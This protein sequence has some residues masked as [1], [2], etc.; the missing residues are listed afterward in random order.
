MKKHG[1]SDS[2]FEYNINKVY[3][4]DEEISELYQ[5]I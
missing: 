2:V 3:K 1:I 4:N 5:L